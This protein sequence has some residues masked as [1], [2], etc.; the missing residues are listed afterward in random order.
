MPACTRTRR[1]AGS[2]ARMR[3]IRDKSRLMPPSSGSGAPVTD[4]PNPQGVTGT[5]C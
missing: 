4:E 3:L 2:R 5:E 1:L